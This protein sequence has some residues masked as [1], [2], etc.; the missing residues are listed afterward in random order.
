MPQNSDDFVL[1]ASLMQRYNFFM[2]YASFE[3]I[4]LGESHIFL[5]PLIQEKRQQK[6]ERRQLDQID[7][8][9]ESV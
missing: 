2:R 6:Q 8:S 5:R 3:A 7:K 9:T 4:I 1:F